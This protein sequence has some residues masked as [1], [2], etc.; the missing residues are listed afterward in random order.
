[1]PFIAQTR[2]I[3]RSA[4]SET[5]PGVSPCGQQSRKMF[6]S[7]HPWRMFDESLPS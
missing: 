4:R 3:S 2:A 5:F 1:L 6:Q 7:G